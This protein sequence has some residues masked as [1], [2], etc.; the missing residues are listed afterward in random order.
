MGTVIPAGGATQ[1]GASADVAAGLAKYTTVRLTVDSSALTPNERRM[2]PLLIDAGDA[3][4]EIYWHQAY[5]NR[6][7]LLSAVRGDAAL[8]RFVEINYGPWDRLANDRP[9]VPGAGP[10]PAGA[11]Y[12]PLDMT[13]GE[14]ETAVATGPKARADSLKSLY[15]LVRR[16]AA[17]RLVAI[18]FSQAYAQLNRRAA[19]RLRE[20]AALADDPGL[21]RYLELR[22]SALLTDDYQPSDLAWMDMKKKTIDVVIGPI[23]T[24]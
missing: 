8:R 19:T 14:F 5:G 17:G 18:P 10:K 23:E 13:K 16:D 6:D 21:R 4:D 7:S 24:Y 2:M 3:M 11:N 12:Y 20:A 1:P 22:A 15:T 9:V